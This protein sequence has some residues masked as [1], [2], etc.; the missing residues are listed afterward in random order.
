MTAGIALNRRGPDCAI[1]LEESGTCMSIRAI[2]AVAAAGLG[3]LAAG[4]Q[5]TG[6]APKAEEQTPVADKPA[7]PAGPDPFASAVNFECEGGGKLDVAFES[8]S[9]PSALVRIDGGAPMK[10]GIDETATE[11]MTYK[12]AAMRVVFDGEALKLTSGGATKMCKFV[13][14]SLPPPVVAGVVR[15]VK[16]EDKGASV[17]MKVGDRISVSLSGVPTAGYVWAADN[18]PAFVKVAEGPGGSTTTSQYL[19]GFAGGNHWE[20][21]IV[22]AVAAGESEIAF[23][24]KRPWEDK[25]D[26]ADERFRFKLTVK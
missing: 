1:N 23:A 6:E 14:R 25:A 9:P 8:G 24:Q 3:L 7:D 13:S 12:D 19:P 16:A 17:E 4:C 2:A 10:L 18:P 20:V 21:L 22:E 15:D 5:P 11:G 26:P